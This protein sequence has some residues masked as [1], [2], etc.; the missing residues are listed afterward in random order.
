MELIQNNPYRIA[1]ILSNATERELQKQKTKIKA[2]TKVGKEIKSDF[3]FQF[4]GNIDRTE[5]SVNKAFSNV[6]QNQD[7]VNYALFWFLNVSPFD[8]TAIEY[9]KNGDEEKALEIWEKVTNDKDVNSKNFSAFNNL[10]TYKLLSRDK[11]DIK[12]GIEAKIKLIESDYFESFVHSVADETYTIDNQKQSEKLIDELL[13]QFKN[14]YSSS[15]TLQLF[16]GCNGTTQRYLSK[17]FTEEPLHKIESQIESCKKKRKADKSRAY[18]FGLKLF[19]NTKDDLS[20]LKSLLGTS[21][22]KYKAVAD[23]LAN[24]IM[25]CGIDYFNESQEN[26]SS[27]DSLKQA[28]ELNETALSIAAGKLTR[29]RAKDSLATLEEMR[30]REVAQAIALL[31]SV[32]D[33]YETNEQKIR[34]QV[35]DLKESDPLIK[36]GHRTINQSAVEDNIKNSIDWGKVNE[37]LK[38]ILPDE[39]LERIKAS[40]KN[41]LKSEFTELANWLKEY[42]QSNSVISRIID[43]YKRIPPKLSFKIVSSEI[44]NTDS[45]PLYTKYIRYIG[46]KVNVEVLQES[47]VTFYLKYINPKGKVDRNK[48]SSPNGYTR[49]DTKN[50][51][52]NSRTIS[53]AGWGNADECTYD[54]G[55]HRIEVY[56][57]E[58]LIHTKKYKVDLAPSEK[59]E[60]E[61]ASAEKKLREIN[62]TDY[63]ESEIRSAKNEMS[64]IQKFK[65]F[66]GSSEKQS[67]IQ[68]QQAKIDKLI[69]Q[70]KEEKKKDVRT[71]EEKIYKLKMEL[72]VAKY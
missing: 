7:K 62:Q 16:S 45:K 49:L 18:E 11:L 36:L 70:A 8:N 48:K 29:D 17:K 65:L 39:S 64:E 42:S 51:N 67:Q 52:K 32:K 71:Q 35:K 54:I 61:I 9:L 59:L 37:L 57:D 47:T 41:E 28:Q 38:E 24:E 58:Y 13:T 33:A 23:Q 25:Q 6:E 30:D 34:Q 3:D 63:Y 22:L 66:R 14:Q 53:F 55:E 15:E 2:Y 12:K 43:K 60:K 26:D 4:L 69:Q 44:T 31:Q 10:G 56:V 1:G 50:L 5:E 20:L 46:L 40:T 19:T 21:D 68:A 72:S 27:D